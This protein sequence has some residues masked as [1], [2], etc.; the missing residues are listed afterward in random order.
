L[1]KIECSPEDNQQISPAAKEAVYAAWDL[2]LDSISKQ[3]SY[4]TDPVNTA[5]KVSKIN[6]KAAELIRDNLSAEDNDL[7]KEDKEKALRIVLSPWTTRDENMLRTWVNSTADG[8]SG[9][10]KHKHAQLLV[11]NILSMGLSPATPADIL[12]PI[13]KDNIELVCWMALEPAPP[14]QL[15]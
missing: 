8:L 10:S 3:W 4:Y 1:R 2:A 5:P 7:S 6:S 13:A 15:K 11:K 12:P 9:L 14:A